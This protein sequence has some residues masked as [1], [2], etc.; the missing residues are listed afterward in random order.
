M[1]QSM[2]QAFS[3]TVLV[4]LPLNATPEDIQEFARR[5]G[6]DTIVFQRSWTNGFQDHQGIFAVAGVRG[7]RLPVQK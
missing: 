2:I 6:M 3:A 5:F 4:V 1:D 7:V